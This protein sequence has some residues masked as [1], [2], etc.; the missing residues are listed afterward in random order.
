MRHGS[1]SQDGDAGQTTGGTARQRRPVTV[2]SVAGTHS[3]DSFA[4]PLLRNQEVILHPLQLLHLR[5]P[6]VVTAGHRGCQSI[7]RRAS[8]ML[9]EMVCSGACQKLRATRGG[10]TATQA[11][12]IQFGTDVIPIASAATHT[13]ITQAT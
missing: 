7:Y 8:R 12:T 4:T 11:T 3:G 13:T 5:I 6:I 9:S 2:T 1:G 10:T